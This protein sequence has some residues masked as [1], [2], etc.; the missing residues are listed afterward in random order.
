MELN[1]AMHANV[2]THACMH[3]QDYLKAAALYTKAIKLDKTNATL[4][5]N[6]SVALLKLK[7][8]SK[9]LDD[10]EECIRL[11]PEWEKGYFR[12]AA[13]Q[14]EQG[15]AGA[16]YETYLKALEIA[17]GNRDLMTRL[18]TVAKKAGKPMPSVRGGVQRSA[19][20]RA[21]AHACVRGKGEKRGAA[22][23]FTVC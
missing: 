18:K 19:R 2:I 22:G 20:F 3:A 6:R 17:P 5:S 7:K 15:E 4:F 13:V 1:F 12:K 11:R 21:D 10:A 8:V 16:A 14:E 23:S 9:A